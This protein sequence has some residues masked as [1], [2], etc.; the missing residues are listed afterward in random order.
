MLESLGCLLGARVVDLFAG[1][2]AMGIE[3]LSRGARSAVFVDSDP[4]AVD[5]VRSNLDATGLSGRETVLVGADVVSWLRHPYVAGSP[6]A[7]GPPRPAGA[8]A[9]GEGRDLFDLAFCDPPYGFDAW[10]E[11]AGSLRAGILVAESDRPLASLTGWEVLRS[12]RY[13]GTV[14]TVMRR[15]TGPTGRCENPGEG[16]ST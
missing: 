2:G 1:S 15:T 6:V 4:R 10:E 8:W 12:R 14:V 9:S 11:V 16:M 7:P 3:A 5:T 13:G